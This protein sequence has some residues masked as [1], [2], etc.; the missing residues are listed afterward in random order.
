M[1][2]LL[3]R[4]IGLIFLIAFLSLYVQYPGLYG[5]NGLLPIQDYSTRIHT[6]FASTFTSLP[7]SFNSY[8]KRYLTFPSLI[9]FSSDL[10]LRADVFGEFLLLIGILY[11]TVISLLG[12][13]NGIL[14]FVIWIC[15]LSH[16]LCGQVF[17]SFQWDILLLEVGFLAFLSS[18]FLPPS[19]LAPVKSDRNRRSDIYK[20]FHWCYRFLIWKLM[21]MAGVVKLQANCPTWLKLTALEVQPV[22]ASPLLTFLF[23]PSLLLFSPS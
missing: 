10:T 22:L 15:Y 13:H 1:A 14:F 16:F 12:S 19:A 8:F 2:S 23:H 6:H 5:A 3:S 17:L 11:S 4:G 7:S 18:L 20:H 9:L 21:F